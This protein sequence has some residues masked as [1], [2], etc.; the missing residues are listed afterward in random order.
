M[1]GMNFSLLRLYNT[2]H[3]RDYNPPMLYALLFE[4]DCLVSNERYLYSEDDIS[5]H[6]KKFPSLDCETPTLR[7]NT[8]HD[9]VSDSSWMDAFLLQDASE[10]VKELKARCAKLSILRKRRAPVSRAAGV[11]KAGNRAEKIK[12]RN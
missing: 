8:P 6:F 5:K 10:L 11:K 2:W 12:T 9:T 1:D 7:E 4:L 3:G